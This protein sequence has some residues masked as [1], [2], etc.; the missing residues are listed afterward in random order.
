MTMLCDLI[1]RPARDIIVKFKRD[2][3]VGLL[4]RTKRHIS[5]LRSP[6]LP[7]DKFGVYYCFDHIPST[8]ETVHGGLVKAQRLNETYPNTPFGFNLLYMVSSYPPPDWQM[9]LHIAHLRGAKVV[10][11]QNGVAY[12]GWHGPGWDETNRP[13]RKRMGAADFVIYQ[14]QF[15]KT[16]ADR[17]LIER[18]YNYQVLYNAVDTRFFKPGQC[19]DVNNKK[20]GKIKLLLGGNQYH[21][22]RYDAA[23]QTVSILKKRGFKILLTVTGKLNWLPEQQECQKI[24]NRMINDLNLHDS[25]VLTGTYL[26]KDFPSLIR[27]SDILLHTQY[28]DACP[29]LVVEAMACGVPIVYSSSGGT[30]ELVGDEAGIGIMAPA[31]WEQI[32]PPD[33]SEL[34]DAVIQVWERLGQFSEAARQRAVEKFDIHP[35]LER[36][37]QIFEELLTQ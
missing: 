36:H 25:V 16:S 2:R 8:D 9:L 6:R 34:A 17:F 7:V 23:L 15:C 30:P 19:V 11:N 32:F 13:A 1:I 4:Q 18:Q 14:S 31:S 28:N 22:Y 5:L 3:I 35:W 20:T 33:P 24:S 27:Q 29:G 37:K 26:Q 10:L 21:F 12:P